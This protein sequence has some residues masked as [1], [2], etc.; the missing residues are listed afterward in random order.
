MTIAAIL[1]FT[2]QPGRREDALAV[3]VPQL[4]DTR[5]HD[6]NLGV[7]VLLDEDADRFLLV[8]RWESAAHNEAYQ[9]WRQ[10]PD[11]AI[12]GFGDLL[13]SPPV[14]RVYPIADS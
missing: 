8:E 7:D 2:A 9:A 14:M 5:R 12:A 3:L 6:G 13:G 11:G 1:E 4:G 10:T